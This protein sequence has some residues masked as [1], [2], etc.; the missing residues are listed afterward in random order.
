MSHYLLLL[1]LLLFITPLRHRYSH[2]MMPL[3]WYILLFTTLFI[4]LLR[5]CTLLRHYAFIFHYCHYCE[6]LPLYYL[7]HIIIT[8]LH[9]AINTPLLPLRL[10]RF[11][12]PLRHYA[13]PWCHYY[14]AMT[15]IM[16]SIIEWWHYAIAITPTLRHYAIID[17]IDDDYISTWLFHYAMMPLRFRY[18]MMITL[19][20]R[21]YAWW[22]PHYWWCHYA[23]P[24]TPLFII[25]II[26]DDTP[27]RW[28]WW[29]WLIITRYWYAIPCHYD[30]DAPLRHWCWYAIMPPLMLLM[31][32]P[33][34]SRH[35]D[36]DATPCHSM[37]MMS[38]HCHAMSAIMLRRWLLRW[39]QHYA[40]I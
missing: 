14:A 3:L 31:M 8:P 37:M 29:W 36:A 25:I 24:I 1:L 26:D 27:L 10:R 4:S 39:Y 17:I 7:R 38:R 35:S 2:Y 12:I 23:M 30:A 9:Y 20:I 11:A 22:A 5:H 21:H 18:A 32:P 13:M 33:L 6:P 16:L 40:I 28:W 34:F 15:F 19:M